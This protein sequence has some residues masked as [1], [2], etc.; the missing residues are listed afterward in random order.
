MLSAAFVE[1]KRFSAR[2][3]RRC[4]PPHS[5]VISNPAPG[6]P[7]LREMREA[8]V[9]GGVSG[10]S[11]EPPGLSG[12]VCVCARGV[13]VRGVQAKAEGVRH[14]AMARAGVQVV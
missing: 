9:S 10:V 4:C 2:H 14:Q 13:C 7:G 12:S 11:V 5:G 8:R 3:E 1:D 6:S